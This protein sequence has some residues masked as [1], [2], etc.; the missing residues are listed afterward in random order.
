MLKRKGG[1]ERPDCKVRKDFVLEGTVHFEA[2]TCDLVISTHFHASWFTW[3]LAF[4]PCRSSGN[5]SMSSRN[6]LRVNMSLCQAMSMY[7]EIPMQ[8]FL[9][10]MGI[11]APFSHA[12]EYANPAKHE[13]IF[14]PS[15]R[16]LR[17]PTR[18][19]IFPS[20]YYTSP[21]ILP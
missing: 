18:R 16:Q 9:D 15:L 19:A 4:I 11:I 12:H 6:H 17:P 7:K 20:T 13:C 8:L 5:S 10:T 3:L 21:Q 1:E 2:H 14:H